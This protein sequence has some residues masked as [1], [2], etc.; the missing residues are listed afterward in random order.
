MPF[1]FSIELKYLLFLD[2]P[3]MIKLLGNGKK[4]S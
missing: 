2:V 3:S 4:Q 1:L